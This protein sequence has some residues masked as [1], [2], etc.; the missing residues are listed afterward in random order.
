MFNF[1]NT[2]ALKSS[3]WFLNHQYKILLNLLFGCF[4]PKRSSLWLCSPKT[5]ADLSRIIGAITP[6]SEVSV[7]GHSAEV[8][9]T[10]REK[11]LKNHVTWVPLFWS[12]HSR[13]HRFSETLFLQD[14][15]SWYA[16]RSKTKIRLTGSV[17]YVAS[18][19]INSL[20]QVVIN[21]TSIKYVDNVKNLGVTI[22]PTLNLNRHLCKIQSNVY[23]ALKSLNFYRRSVYF[24]M[25]KQLDRILVMPFSSIPLSYTQLFR[26][27]MRK[28]SRKLTQRLHSFHNCLCPFYPSIQRNVEH[29]AMQAKFGLGFSSKSQV[30]TATS[31]FLHWK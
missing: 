25:K 16:D 4:P 5:R 2:L 12:F 13:S 8:L 29:N 20:T 3:L 19:D 30:L 11:R 31:F 10:S 17:P 9:W 23:G 24:E 6:I 18:I 15:W 28:I 14:L 26:Q 21:A 7:I 1:E 22:T 27:D